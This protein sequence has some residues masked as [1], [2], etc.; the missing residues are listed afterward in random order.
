MNLNKPMTNKLSTNSM[1]A[2]AEL[3]EALHNFKSMAEVEQD[4]NT[5]W[6]MKEAYNDMAVW[7]NFFL[8]KTDSAMPLALINNT[9]KTQ[10][11]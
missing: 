11:V 10:K 6:R 7:F 4:A 2:T 8:T 3:H 5:A 1:V 9:D